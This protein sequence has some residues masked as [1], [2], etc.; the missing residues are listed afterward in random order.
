MCFNFEVNGAQVGGDPNVNYRPVCKVLPMGW[1][2]S[3]GIMQQVSR[4]VLL[5][6]GL[7]PCMELQKVDGMPR[8][9]TNSVESADNDRAWWQVYLD[10]FMAGES[11]TGNRGIVNEILHLDAMTAWDEAGILRRSRNFDSKGQTGS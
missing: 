7:S 1:S 8:W 9:F 4:Q 6:K 2:S 3:V 11:T 5:M 10:N